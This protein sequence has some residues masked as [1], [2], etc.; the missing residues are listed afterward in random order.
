VK[1]S[2]T[3]PRTTIFWH[4]FIYLAHLYGIFPCLFHTSQE[5]GYQILFLSARAIS[6]AHHTRQFL[7][8]LNQ[9]IH[10]FEIY[11][12][13]NIGQNKKTKEGSLHSPVCFVIIQDGKVLP[14]GPVV[15]SPD[16]LFPSLYREGI[17]IPHY[18]SSIVVFFLLSIPFYFSLLS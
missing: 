3:L 11:L 4:L 17:L 2:F 16:G 1:L 6:Q 8:N 15:I 7:L 9:V 13:F 18:S 5:N 10:Y 12:Y 14:D